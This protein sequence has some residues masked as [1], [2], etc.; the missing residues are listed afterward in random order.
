V[1]QLV[2]GAPNNDFGQALALALNV[3]A[4]TWSLGGESL[5]T[6]GLAAQ[7]GFDVTF[8]GA[9]P[10][11]FDVGASAAAFGIAAGQSTTLTLLQILQALDRQYSPATGTFY[12]G[13]AT[14]TAEAY[15]VL[16]AINQVGQ[17]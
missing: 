4:S 2:A 16:N 17:H 14:L 3:Y 15:R 7:L 9:G 13:N 8:P 12:G 6:N 1:A 11:T 5:V 10:T